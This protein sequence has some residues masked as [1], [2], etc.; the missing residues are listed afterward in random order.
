MLGGHGLINWANDDKECYELSLTLIEKAARYLADNDL[1]EAAFGGAK[2]ANPSDSERE[3]LLVDLLPKL[4]GL[5]S[6]E[7]RFISTVQ[8]DD[9]ILSF[10]NSVDAARLA[11]LG[12]S[13]PDHFLRTKIKPLYVDW[14]P[15]AEDANA[16]ISKLAKRHRAISCRLQRL[17]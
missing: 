7:S 15:Q 11:E 2:Y 17:L 13:C 9:D 14:D 16:L 3:A 10:V 8:Y 6:R 12:T 5:I 1:G 4:R